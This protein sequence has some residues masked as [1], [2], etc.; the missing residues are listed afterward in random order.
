MSNLINNFIEINM[1]PLDQ[2]KFYMK[3]HKLKYIRRIFHLLK[4]CQ[5]QNLQIS[6]CHRNNNLYKF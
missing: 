6:L 4:Y 5:N 2:Q 3:C 1:L